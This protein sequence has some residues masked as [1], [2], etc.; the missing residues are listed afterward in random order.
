MEVIR[1]L[2]TRDTTA[3]QIFTKVLLWAAPCLVLKK[4]HSRACSTV[5]VFW[6]GL[7]I[8]RQEPS[9]RRR[10][11]SKPEPGDAGSGPDYRQRTQSLPTHA[12]P[13]CT[14]LAS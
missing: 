13:L 5:L 14:G 10:G 8:K 3:C 9:A 4:G 6:D 7:W 2:G 11:I 12:F 1:D